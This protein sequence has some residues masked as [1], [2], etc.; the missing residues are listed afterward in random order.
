[1]NQVGT[2]PSF[3]ETVAN[4]LGNIGLLFRQEIELAKAEMR[5]TVAQTRREVTT[6]AIAG[7]IILLG[8]LALLAA[9]ILALALVV[10][11][12]LSALIIGA[13]LAGVGALMLRRAL[14]GMQSVSFVPE[15]TVESMKRNAH[16]VKES[17]S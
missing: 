2:P 14:A 8:V 13:L 4:L 7:V 16:M 9:A 15:R 17:L 3:R 10:P 6:I 1:M 11:A 12:W 5:E